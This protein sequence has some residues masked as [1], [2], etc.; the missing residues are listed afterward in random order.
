QIAYEGRPKSVSGNIW[1]VPQAKFCSG[2][3]G[4]FV[5]PHEDD[6]AGRAEQRP[7]TNGIPLND[8]NMASKRFGSCKDGQHG[9]LT[10]IDKYS[11]NVLLRPPLLPA[12]YGQCIANIGGRVHIEP[13]R[14]HYD[15]NSARQ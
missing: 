12:E 7:T 8:G 2:F 3:R 14:T 6:L 1:N 11:T 5:V 15:R 13:V 10:S 9:I 4:A